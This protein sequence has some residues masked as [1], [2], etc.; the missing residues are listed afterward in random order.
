MSD[1]VVENAF[2][3][4]EIVTT[5][6]CPDGPLQVRGHQPDC[7]FPWREDVDTLRAAIA[8]LTA[9]AEAARALTAARTDS[10]FYRGL[11][12]TGERALSALGAALEALDGGDR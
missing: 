5:C 11:D 8:R 4:L 2:R 12:D 9:V 6:T 7:R 10:W 1:P 3:E